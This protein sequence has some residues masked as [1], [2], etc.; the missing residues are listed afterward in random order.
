M[1]SELMTIIDPGALRSANVL[2]WSL[3]SE[4]IK[5]WRQAQCMSFECFILYH[6]WVVQVAYR[7]NASKANHDIFLY[8]T[9]MFDHLNHRFVLTFEVLLPLI[10]LVRSECIFQI[11]LMKKNRYQLLHF[12]WERTK[13]ANVLKVY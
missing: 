6:Q 1:F 13:M 11:T 3:I 9:M 4:N 10:P 2:K 5:N 7:L 8:I 12:G